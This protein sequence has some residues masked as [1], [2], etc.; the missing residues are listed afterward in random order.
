MANVRDERVQA[1]IMQDEQV[2]KEIMQYVGVHDVTMGKDRVR[3]SFARIDEVVE[4]PDLIEVQKNSYQRFLKED[5]KEVL[6]DVSPITDFNGNLKLEFVDYTLDP[7]PK[8]SIAECRERDMTYATALKVLV[9]LTNNET[10]EVKESEVFMGDFPLMTEH[11]TFIVNGGER[12]IVSQLVRSPGVYY[13]ESIDK[14]GKHLFDTQVIPN[15]GAWLEYEIDSNDVMWVRVDRARKLPVTSLLRALGYGSDQEIIDLLGDDEK[16]RAT[17]GKDGGDDGT[18]RRVTTGEP[19]TRESGLMDIYHRLR[20]GEIGTVDSAEKLLQATFFDTRRYDMMRVGRYKYNKKLSIAA[21]IRGFVA[22]ADIVDPETGEVLVAEGE[23]IP[24]SKTDPLAQR[25][26]NCGVNDI[27]LRLDD[28]DVRVIGNNFVDAAAW[29]DQETIDAVG[30]NEMVHLPTLKELLA[31][32]EEEGLEGEERIQMLKAN[33]AALSPKHILIDDIVASISYLINLPYGVG[34]VDDIDH[35]GNRRLRSVGELLQNQIRIGLARLER[36]VRE[37]MSVQNQ[38]DVKPQDLINIRPVSAA[39][40]EFF[41]SSQLSQFMDQPNPL[42]ELTHKRRLSAL[43][44]GGLNRDR[45]SF[46]VRDV[47][48]SHYSRICP[49]ETPEGPNIGLIGSLATYARINEYGFIEA[50]YRRIDHSGDVPH[51]MDEIVYL[52]ADEEDG[53]MIAQAREPLNP[54]GTF[55]NDRVTVRVRADVQSVE[56]ERVD[57][58]DV[59]PRQ[60]IS[61]ATAMIPFLDHDDANRA[62][63]GSNMQ[64]QAV[65]LLRPEAAYVATGIESKA[66]KDSG[67]CLLAKQDGFVRKVTA[68]TIVIE[69]EMHECHEYH[70][71]KFARSNQSTCINQHPIVSVGEK[72]SMGDVIADGP[73]T[74]RGEISL[75]RNVLIGFMTWEGYNYEDAV[76]LSEELV[77][78]DTFTSIH[79]EKYECE[80]RDT[81]LGAEEITRDLPNVGDDALKDLDADG[82]IRIGAEVHPGDILV[83]KVT[84]KGETELTAEER[85]LRAIFGEKAREVR[86]TSLKVPHGEEGIIVDV[87]VFDRKDH[88]ELAPGV[89]R[90]VRVYIAQKRKISVGDKMAGRHG[91]KGVVSRVLRKEDMPFLPDGTPLQIVLNPLG[92]PSRMNLGQ[93][94]EVHLGLAAKAL[95][96]HVATPDFDGATFESIEKAYGCILDEAKRRQE[97]RAA[98]PEEERRA[99]PPTEGLDADTVFLRNVSLRG[100]ENLDGKTILYDGR[101]GDQFCNPVTVGYMYYL[102]LHHLVDDKMHARST[103]PYS[104]VTQQPLGGKAQFGGQR[105][106]EMEVWALEAYGAANTLQEILTVKSD[107]VVGRVKAYEAIVKGNNIPAPGVPESFKVLIKE[108]E[109]LS[110][111]VRVLDSDHSEIVIKELD[112]EDEPYERAASTTTREPAAE[113]TQDADDVGYGPVDTEALGSF[114][115]EEEDFDEDKIGDDADVFAG[116]DIDDL[117]MNVELPDLDDLDPADE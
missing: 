64:R 52:A 60:V 57:Y 67:V 44:P 79:L 27:M 114:G 45:A 47:H 88:A 95:G 97:A 69:D 111:N 100:D 35:L 76:L 37:R 116:M 59:S 13:R 77:M 74:D 30:I 14:A 62:L 102:K 18:R 75:G 93:V 55:V 9:R 26:Q 32:C 6:A 4:M 78:N 96:W 41:G 50:P 8:H 16:L 51:V 36:V 115:T 28:R 3:K 68:D 46:E 82:I 33:L 103:G 1:G 81:K 106:G 48:Y 110:L 70:L 56:P 2:Q 22:A 83:G 19:K 101:T 109:S 113:R 39:I 21:R 71:T 10:G 53:C 42:A 24:A 108:L 90:M 105:F 43:G 87:K 104:L 107:D 94:L 112:D 54:D 85:L 89:N 72:V 7:T 15:R 80:A 38:T 23:R 91:N 58:I 61:V 17:M 49:I 84:P 11:G 63:M 92:V 20:P 117:D 40:K 66:G 25:I 12:V 31:R 86:D 5:L 29:L 65:P 99:N 34:R 73:A 98:M